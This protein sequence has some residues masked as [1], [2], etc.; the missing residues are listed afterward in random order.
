[1]S[2]GHFSRNKQLIICP[3][4]PNSI[5]PDGK[6]DL[7]LVLTEQEAAHLVLRV[8]NAPEDLHDLLQ[9]ANAQRAQRLG[10]EEGGDKGN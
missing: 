10:V 5:A 8:R 1:M 3:K 6:D 9:Q 7:R 4:K 2:A